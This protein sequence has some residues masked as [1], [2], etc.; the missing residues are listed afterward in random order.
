[1]LAEFVSVCPAPAATEAVLS[2]FPVAAASMVP[3]IVMVRKLVP[4]T[5]ILTPV[6]RRLLPVDASVP[7][8]A[9]P[10]AKQL[11]VTP[12]MAAGM[13]SVTLAPT[14]FDGPALST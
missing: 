10:L 11:I 12:V 7:Q 9:V 13:V 5:G 3:F 2:R 1:M 6:K 8:L 4:P 14:A